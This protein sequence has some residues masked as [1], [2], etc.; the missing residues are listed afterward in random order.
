MASAEEST[1]TESPL[2]RSRL[3]ERRRSLVRRRPKQPNSLGRFGHAASCSSGLVTSSL[4]VSVELARQLSLMPESLWEWIWGTDLHDLRRL[5]KPNLRAES[6][7]PSRT[8]RI[9]GGACRIDST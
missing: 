2:G 6:G 1:R 3:E 7:S 4:S 9:C 5:A 8:T